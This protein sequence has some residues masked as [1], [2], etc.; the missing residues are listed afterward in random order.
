MQGR[1]STGL[2]PWNLTRP[3]APDR[4]ESHRGSAQAG[5]EGRPTWSR[6]RVA[7]TAA[8]AAAR[9]EDGGGVEVAE[10]QN[11]FGSDEEQNWERG[12]GGLQYR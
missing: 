9:E 1:L 7:V 10:E 4:T 2:Q 3:A 5:R 11:F 12:R 6:K 8:G